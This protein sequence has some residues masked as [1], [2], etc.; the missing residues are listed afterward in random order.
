MGR[1]LGS[2]TCISESD[3]AW[4]KPVTFHFFSLIPDCRQANSSCST[5]TGLPL[6]SLPSFARTPAARKITVSK[7][8]NKWPFKDLL[9]PLIVRKH[10]N[11]QQ[12]L[13]MAAVERSGQTQTSILGGQ[14]Y[15]LGE[16]QSMERRQL[17]C[18]ERREGKW[19]GGW[20]VI[21]SSRSSS[22]CKHGGEDDTKRE[23]ARKILETRGCELT[24]VVEASFV[25]YLEI[26]RRLK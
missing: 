25:R 11:N 9:T 16:S 20:G 3:E 7:L 18:A 23:S 10:L 4:K 12:R 14:L 1:E 17:P 2:G 24:C 15:L 6:H 5:E 26:C 19:G 13:I 22:G 8:L 21:V